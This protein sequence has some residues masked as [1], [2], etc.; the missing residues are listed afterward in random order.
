METVA[1]LPQIF[2]IKSFNSKGQLSEFHNDQS[3]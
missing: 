2:L 3:L 1:K